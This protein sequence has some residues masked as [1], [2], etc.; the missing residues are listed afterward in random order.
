MSLGEQFKFLQAAL[1]TDP[2]NEFFNTLMGIRLLNNGQLKQAEP[3]LM[4][5][6][7]ADSALV[8]FQ[9][10]VLKQRDNKLTEAVVY[11]ERALAIEAKPDQYFVLILT[12]INSGALE[13][14]LKHQSVAS[15]SYPDDI[16]FTSLKGRILCA[17][18]KREEALHWCLENDSESAGPYLLR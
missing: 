10:G 11:F 8:W 16:R 9:L 1:A 18:G 2:E 14:A 17:Q 3:C 15:A 5:A 7:R 12:C 4:I 13:K 6:S